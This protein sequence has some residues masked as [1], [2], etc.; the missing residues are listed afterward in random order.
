MILNTYA[1]LAAF[2]SVLGFLLGLLILGFGLFALRQCWRQGDPEAKKAVESRSALLLLLALL[3]VSLNVVSWPLLYLLLQ[4]YVPQWPG[5]MCIYGVTQVGAGSLGTSRFLPGLLRTLQL[6]K[7]LLVFLSGAWFVLYVIN[8]R[9]A[10]A[11]LIRR[12]FV[13]MLVVAALAEVDALAEGAYLVIP[14]KEEFLASGCCTEVLDDAGRHP[15]ALPQFI[16]GEELHPWLTP[17]YY[18][19]NAGMILALFG[20]ALRPRAR[21]PVT[22]MASLL[23]GA[24]LAVPI[25]AVFLVEIAAPTILHLPYH[26]CAYD[27]IPRAPETVLGI[28]LFLWGTFSVGWAC[29]AAWL[30]SCQETRNLLPGR[31][32]SLLLLA[33]YCYLASLILISVELALA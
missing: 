12:V 11:P 20:F 32:R 14:K 4:S 19:L 21:F 26:H 6:T 23:L 25:S 7:P 2:T 27:L 22:A 15:Q 31:V 3:L 5:V 28:A 16:V 33:A 18:V 30:G 8:R 9:C 10:T 13:V 17:A 1:V 24:A 29:V